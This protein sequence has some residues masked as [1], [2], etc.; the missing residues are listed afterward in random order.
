MKKKILQISTMAL[1]LGLYSC[2]EAQKKVETITEKESK[3]HLINDT[4]IEIPIDISNSKILWE[5]EKVIL[6]GHNGKIQFSEGWIKTTDQEDI[7]VDAYFVVDLNSIDVIDLVQEPKNK[8]ELERHLKSADFFDVATYPRAQFKTIKINHVP[9]NGDLNYL[10]IGELTIKNITKTIE[11][12][13]QFYISDSKM[14]LK[15]DFNINRIDFG[16]IYHSKEDK[17]FNF[18]KMMDWAIKDTIK[19]KA[20]IFAPMKL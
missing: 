17:T 3:D 13:V 19:L 8:S 7:L 20:H 6:G 11:V 12:P 10:L 4:S 16:I 14:V 5:G 1:I 9:E 18:E 2:E 15:A